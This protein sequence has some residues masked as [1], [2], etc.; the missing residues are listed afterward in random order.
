[1]F[2]IFYFLDLATLVENELM[3]RGGFNVDC[4][5]VN[6]GAGRISFVKKMGAEIR[7]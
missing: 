3:L 7:H 1:M 4:A 6:T 2:D 5:G